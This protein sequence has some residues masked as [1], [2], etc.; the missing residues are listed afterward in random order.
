MIW[1]ILPTIE[2]LQ[3]ASHNTL[4]ETLGIEFREIGPDY[5]RARMPVDARTVQ[6]FGILHGGA[7]VALGESLASLGANLCVDPEFYCVGLEINA[8]HLRAVRQ[9]WVEG[10][11]RPIHLGKRFQVWQVEIYREGSEE[12][13]CIIRHTV[14]VLPKGQGPAEGLELPNG[15]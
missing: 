1:K 8:N 10:I 13:V 14:A 4:I 12:K 3:A 6:N 7:S 9:G 5:I 2:A 11:A 15:R